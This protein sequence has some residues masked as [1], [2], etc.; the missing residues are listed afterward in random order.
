MLFYR[1]LYSIT[2]GFIQ[3]MCKSLSSLQFIK[4]ISPRNHGL[5]VNETLSPHPHSI[6]CWISV[7]TMSN[8]IQIISSQVLFLLLCHIA[9]Y[10]LIT[11]T[12][13]MCLKWRSTVYKPTL[14]PK[15]ENILPDFDNSHRIIE[16]NCKEEEDKV[17]SV[18][19]VVSCTQ[20]G[21]QP[22][23]EP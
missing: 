11:F 19:S 6:I 14:F 13:L 17:M 23:W 2:Y 10:I 7:W 15:L 5:S 1:S 21:V 22:V 18:F 9:Y 3:E 8:G 4:D 16:N 20:S 12:K